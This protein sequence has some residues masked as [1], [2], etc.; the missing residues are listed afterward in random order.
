MKS[1]FLFLAI[2]LVMELVASAGWKI[3]RCQKN[4]GGHCRRQCLHTERHWYILLRALMA[5][6]SNVFFGYW[7]LERTTGNNTQGANPADVILPG[8]IPLGF[9]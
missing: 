8:T 9:G 1:L 6:L 7:T 5:Q 4:Y 2:L 3:Q